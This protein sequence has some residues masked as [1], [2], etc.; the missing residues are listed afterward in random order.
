ME[1][2]DITTPQDDELQ[3]HNSSVINSKFSD[4]TAEDQAADERAIDA[5]KTV[6]PPSVEKEETKNPD[7]GSEA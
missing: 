6:S 2:Q 4:A 1:T 3:A 5:A 7:S